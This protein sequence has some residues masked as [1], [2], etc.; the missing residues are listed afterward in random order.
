M[1]QS[2]SKA[3]GGMVTDDPPRWQRLLF[4]IVYAIVADLLLWL[5]LFLA[6]I[7]FV[8][9]LIN[10]EVNA[11]LREFAGRVNAY[12]GEIIGFLSF[13]RN[14]VPFPFAPFPGPNSEPAKPARGRRSPKKTS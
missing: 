3:R 10:D 1:A 13:S 2:R 14:A 6:L 11:N 5:I 8:L 12:F 9:W 4:M 7:Q